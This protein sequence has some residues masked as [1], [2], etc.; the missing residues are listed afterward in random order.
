M[1]PFL[2]GLPFYTIFFNFGTP[3]YKSH[4]YKSKNFPN[5]GVKKA[6]QHLLRFGEKNRCKNAKN[7]AAKKKN[8][9]V[10]KQHTG[11]KKRKMFG[12]KNANILV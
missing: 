4:I 7:F 5:N 3:L 2:G 10:K 6:L 9:G 1:T 8:V 12:V 11:V